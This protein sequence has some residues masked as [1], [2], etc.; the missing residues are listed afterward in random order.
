MRFHRT[1]TTR[2]GGVSRP[3]YDT[4]NLGYGVPDDPEAVREN[5][6]RVQAAIGVAGVAWMRQVH[7][8]TVATVDTAPER[9]VPDTDGL[10]TRTPKL[11]LAVL[12]A[13]CVPVL[14]ADLDGLVIGAAHAGRR[15]AAGGIAIRLIEGMG[16][17]A[18]RIDVLL[19]P[20][21]CGA[22]YEVP[23]Q[24][25]AEVDRVLPGSACTTRDGT[26]GLDL[27]AGLA[28]QLRAAGVGRITI[29]DRCTR[30]DENLYS[31]RRSPHTGRQAGL[32]WLA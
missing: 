22:C 15:G 8:T 2:A 31:H 17:P 11:A 7:G 26:T 21:I 24:M 12:I 23:P 16:V 10:V 29:D 4:L 3:P 14:A 25:Q 30:E 18:D 9:A 1:V 27:R 32:I 13:D 28:V 19:G 5:R 6:S 20:A